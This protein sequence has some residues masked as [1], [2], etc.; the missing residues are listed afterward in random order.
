MQGPS[1]AFEGDKATS[2]AQAQLSAQDT[3]IRYRV[4]SCR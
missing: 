3:S 4:V 2:A 1:F